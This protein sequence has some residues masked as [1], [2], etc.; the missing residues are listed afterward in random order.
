MYPVASAHTYKNMTFSF[1]CI[2]KRTVFTKQPAHIKYYLHVDQ[3]DSLV[4]RG[5]MW[6]KL[7]LSEYLSILD[8]T[9]S[10]TRHQSVSVYVSCWTC[11]KSSVQR[12]LFDPDR[13][14]GE[15]LAVPQVATQNILTELR[16]VDA[17]PAGRLDA[18][19]F[20]EETFEDLADKQTAEC[21]RTESTKK[22]L[23]KYK[24][25]MDRKNASWTLKT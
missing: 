12:L 6:P 15:G 18:E 20:L 8:S 23:I 25:L 21:F 2:H 4:C 9:V 17:P 16:W 5:V 10:Q 22:V 13:G 7:M 19:A 24:Q 3:Y 1:I 11:G 14:A